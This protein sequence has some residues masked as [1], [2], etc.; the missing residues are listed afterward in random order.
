MQFSEEVKAILWNIIEVLVELADAKD[1]DVIS[2]GGIRKKNY[3]ALVGPRAMLHSASQ[4]IFAADH[5]KFHK[6]AFSK[7]CRIEG[8]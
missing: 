4:R 8:Y 3:L 5:S 6:I 1:W 7:I 2:T